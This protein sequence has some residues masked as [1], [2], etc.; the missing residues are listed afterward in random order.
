MSDLRTNHTGLLFSK[1]IGKVS[2]E[3]RDKFN[4]EVRACLLLYAL[5]GAD[6]LQT[7]VRAPGDGAAP[8][9]SHSLLFF[10]RVTTARF[11]ALCSR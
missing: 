7:H 8:L 10:R 3:A 11:L 9:T 1:I 4:A 6:V 2:E 5:G